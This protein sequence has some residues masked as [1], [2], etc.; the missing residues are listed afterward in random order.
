MIGH[1]VSNA[2][3]LFMP[4]IIFSFFL[5]PSIKIPVLVGFRKYGL[6]SLTNPMYCLYGNPIEYAEAV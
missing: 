3:S 1:G 2:I 4:G 6:E 5:G